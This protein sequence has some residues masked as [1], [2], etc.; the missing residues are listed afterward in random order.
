[1]TTSLNE[2]KQVEDFLHGK[3]KPE[4]SL[5][6]RAKLLINPVLRKNVSMQKKTYS[7]IR[8]YGRRKLKLEIAFVQEKIFNDPGKESYKKKIEKIFSNF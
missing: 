6:F 3:L 5:F 7:L 4:E 1:M 2:I 8:L